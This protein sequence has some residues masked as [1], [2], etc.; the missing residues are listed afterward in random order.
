VLVVLVKLST[1]RLEIIFHCV[2]TKH[3]GQLFLTVQYNG[4][5]NRNNCPLCSVRTRHGQG[6]V[7]GEDCGDPVADRGRPA[8]A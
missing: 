3:N 4:L 7:K 8:A 1:A 6:S 5:N 2:L